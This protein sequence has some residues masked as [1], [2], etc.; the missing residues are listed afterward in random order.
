MHVYSCSGQLEIIER[1]TKSAQINQHRSLRAKCNYSAG[2][3]AVSLTRTNGPDKALRHHSRNA[4]IASS[5]RGIENLDLVV[6]RTKEH[7]IIL[8]TCTPKRALIA[9]TPPVAR[10]WPLSQWQALF[11][12]HKGTVRPRFRSPVTRPSLARD[13]VVRAGE[14][15]LADCSPSVPSAIVDGAQAHSARLWKTDANVGHVGSW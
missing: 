12:A 1:E 2:H 4:V 8:T 15:T 9:E 7:E 5:G 11:R 14:R 3:T 13:K 10:N 6:N